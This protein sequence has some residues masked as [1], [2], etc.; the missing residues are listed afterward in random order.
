VVNTAEILMLSYVGGR[1]PSV[2]V[3]VGPGLLQTG[4]FTTRRS[5]A[6]AYRNQTFDVQTSEVRAGLIPPMGWFVTVSMDD[7]DGGVES[8]YT[9]TGTYN[10]E[11]NDAR[12]RCYH[13]FG[14]VLVPPTV[15]SSTL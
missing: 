2:P 14:M 15:L 11:Q 12:R 5:A 6:S 1:P 7:N 4:P 13:L 3:I 9:L 8:A 10:I